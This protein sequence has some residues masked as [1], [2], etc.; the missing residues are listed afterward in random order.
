[1][2]FLKSWITQVM[3]VAL[4]IA[5]IQL[6]IPN[7]RNR[8][9]INM[10]LGIVMILTITSPL[11]N[12]VKDGDVENVDRVLSVISKNARNENQKIVKIQNSQKE[13]IKEQVLKKLESEIESLASNKGY[14]ANV[15]TNI[16]DSYNVNKIYIV[17]NNKYIDKKT[18]EI[19]D[20]TRYISEQ[21]K[22]DIDKI[23]VSVQG[24]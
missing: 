16:D 14:E 7:N 15:K 8:K 20:L 9:Y 3:F 13:Y 1:M 10:I 5:I 22:I 17:L 6:I 21:I 2:D 11:I 24:E 23:E 18:E 12:K 19:L 4:F